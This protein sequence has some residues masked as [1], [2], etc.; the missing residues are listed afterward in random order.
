MLTINLLKKK[1]FFFFP[2]NIKLLKIYAL[3]GFWNFALRGKF[4]L[5]RNV[6][7]FL[8]FF[9]AYLLLP[10]RNSDDSIL[11]WPMVTL[12]AYVLHIIHAFCPHVRFWVP[13]S[14]NGLRPFV[15]VD[16][17]EDDV[18]P[19]DVFNYA[20]GNAKP[21]TKWKKFHFFFFFFIL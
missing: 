6:F 8:I 4:Y 5:R 21:E 12:T 16:S 15:V 2:Q 1:I 17:F 9:Y 20:H 13:W 7:F 18:A 3:S 10:I 19:R 14:F 11:K